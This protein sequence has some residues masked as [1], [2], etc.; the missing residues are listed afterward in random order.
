ML[1]MDGSGLSERLWAAGL[2]FGS[3]PLRGLSPGF[4]NPEVGEKTGL[5]SRSCYRFLLRPGKNL[6]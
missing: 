5:E 6:E 2:G 3:S 1:P 4:R